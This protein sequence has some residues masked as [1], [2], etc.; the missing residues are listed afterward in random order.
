MEPEGLELDEFPPGA[1]E[2]A[3]RAAQSALNDTSTSEPRTRRSRCAERLD[4]IY[5][6]LTCESISLVLLLPLPLTQRMPLPAFLATGRDDGGRLFDMRRASFDH[7]SR[8]PATAFGP[9]G[10]S[11]HAAG[12]PTATIHEPDSSFW[13]AYK[14]ALRKSAEWVTAGATVAS[15]ALLVYLHTSYVGKVSC[16]WYRS[17]E[18]Q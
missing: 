7:G 18:Q 12:P 8:R 9:L 5:N 11:M 2:D 16:A 15:L 17:V 6:L 10:A 13:T 1:G 3:Q 14:N 4:Y